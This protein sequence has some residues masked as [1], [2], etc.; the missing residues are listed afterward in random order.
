MGL[1]L[2]LLLL[3]LTQAL[4]A[5]GEDL[6]RTPGVTPHELGQ[7][8]EVE[9]TGE[10]PAVHS[11]LLP[12]SAP[13]IFLFSVNSLCSAWN[14]NELVSVYVQASDN[15]DN[16][17]DIYEMQGCRSEDP[18]F[19][20]ASSWAVAVA[21]GECLVVDVSEGVTFTVLFVLLL[22]GMLVM[23]LMLVSSTVPLSALLLVYS[24]DMASV[25]TLMSP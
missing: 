12:K 5:D 4:G 16:K 14:G 1:A 21:P 7:G 19:P 25:D 23:L 3:L 17:T 8:E 18:G 11:F 13:G 10:W 9:L 6:C 20:Q 2:S 22:L 24:S 15:S